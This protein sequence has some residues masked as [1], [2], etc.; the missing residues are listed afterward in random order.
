MFCARGQKYSLRDLRGNVN[1]VAVY[2]DGASLPEKTA[3][4]LA[5][6]S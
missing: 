1:I 2:L 5:I 4:Q 3:N 6:A